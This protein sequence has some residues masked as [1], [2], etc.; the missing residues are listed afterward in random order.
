MKASL[1]EIADSYLNIKISSLLWQSFILRIG[2]VLKL[3]ITLRVN[4]MVDQK[5]KAKSHMTTF[6]VDTPL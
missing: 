6:G 5:D 4:R 1:F 2:V 3:A